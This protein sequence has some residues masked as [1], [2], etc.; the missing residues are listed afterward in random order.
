MNFDPRKHI[1]P[2]GHGEVIAMKP[3]TAGSIRILGNP[4]TDPGTNLCSLIQTLDPG[5]VVPPHRHE[6]SEQVLY[7]IAGCGEIVIAGETGQATPGV[8]VHVPKGIT[9]AIRN[10]GTQ[11]L[12]F[13]ETTSPPGFE[14]A[15]REL[16]KLSGSK[17][18]E[19]AE[20]LGRHDILIV[21]EAGS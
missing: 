11:P 5:A 3:P 2:A 20:T 13:L 18:T 19:V 8:T 17:P 12:S 4:A 7:F 9:H 15:F 14:R 16:E 6:K 10:S 1:F 21:S